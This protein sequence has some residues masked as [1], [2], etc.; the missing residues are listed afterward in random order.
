MKCYIFLTNLM[1]TLV[2]LLV[3]QSQSTLFSTF[4]DQ[5]KI[6]WNLQEERV[7]FYA[8]FKQ[9]NYHNNSNTFY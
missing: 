8:T 9:K 6:K 3:C 4:T 5:E 1:A 2:Q 7:Y